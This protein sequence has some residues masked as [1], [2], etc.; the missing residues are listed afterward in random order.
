MCCSVL[1]N[2]IY[3]N[4][5]LTRTV[6]KVDELFSVILSW[7]L[8]FHD[9]RLATFCKNILQKTYK[10]FS[11]LFCELFALNFL[12][13]CFYNCCVDSSYGNLCLMLKYFCTSAFKIGRWSSA[14]FCRAI[15]EWL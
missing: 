4:A 7:K 3:L 13:F 5:V 12:H 10:I 11:H 1:A 2:E 14:E 6:Y 9:T 8:N 15:N